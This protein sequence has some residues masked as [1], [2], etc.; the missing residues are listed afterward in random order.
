MSFDMEIDPNDFSEGGGM[1]MWGPQIGPYF[2]YKIPNSKMVVDAA[3]K[4]ALNGAY[5]SY[6]LPEDQLLGF[7]F[8]LRNNLNFNFRYSLLMANIGYEWGKIPTEIETDDFA[9]SYSESI[10]TGMFK[11]G[12]GLIW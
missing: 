1:F 3:Y 10:P 11:F 9:V 4:I 12:I 6:T 8:G 2:S 7:G 5:Y